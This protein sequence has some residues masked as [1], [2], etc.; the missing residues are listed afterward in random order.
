MDNLEISEAPKNISE[1]R[2]DDIPRFGTFVRELRRQRGITQA[3]L[4]GAGINHHQQVD[5]EKNQFVP[6][7]AEVKKIALKLNQDPEGLELLASLSR[8]YLNLLQSNEHEQK[9]PSWE[10]WTR[11]LAPIVRSKLEKVA[12]EPGDAHQFLMDLG[13][14]KIDD[15]KKEIPRS[16]PKQQEIIDRLSQ[17]PY[18]VIRK[19]A[20][21]LDAIFEHRRWIWNPQ[22]L[23]RREESIEETL[24]ELK[25][26]FPSGSWRYV[27]SALGKSPEG[28]TDHVKEVDRILGSPKWRDNHAF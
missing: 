23:M 18:E 8:T 26:L 19:R 9:V 22:L 13:I 10:E 28:L 6:D 14:I 3:Q 4:E 25:K 1:R 7:T 24:W 16:T 17:F 15:Q 20:E 27:P 11:N 5:L 21:R 2:T 12:L